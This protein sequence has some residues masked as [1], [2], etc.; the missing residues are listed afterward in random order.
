MR[1]AEIV[2]REASAYVLA[3]RS[4]TIP[5]GGMIDAALGE[6]FGTLDRHGIQPLG[7]VFF[8]YDVIRMPELEMGFGVLVPAGTPALGALQA[9]EL[10]AGR[11]VRHLHV[12]PYDDLMAATGWVL[13]WVRSQGLALDKTDAPDGEHFASRFEMYLT[14]PAEEPDPARHE[15]EIWMKLRD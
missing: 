8:K 6:V 12:G 13:D 14:D 7:P 11:Y 15:T 3:P 9:G 1:S 5:F 4:V 2:M 10:P